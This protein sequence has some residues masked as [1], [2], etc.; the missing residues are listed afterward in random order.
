MRVPFLSVSVTFTLY[1][2]AIFCSPLAPPRPRLVLGTYASIVQRGRRKTRATSTIMANDRNYTITLNFTS[3]I[4]STRPRNNL[5]A[6]ETEEARLPNSRGYYPYS[7]QSF[8][9][10]SYTS[11]PI[12][13]EVPSVYTYEFRTLKSVSGHGQFAPLRYTVDKEVVEATQCLI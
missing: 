6:N 4:P 11:C 7:G 2:T 13:A 1:S 10:C 3:T 5:V 12:Q 9:G 8:N